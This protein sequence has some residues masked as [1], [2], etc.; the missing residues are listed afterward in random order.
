MPLSS[1][2]GKIA[3]L[4][5][6]GYEGDLRVTAIERHFGVFRLVHFVLD[7]ET[8]QPV[9]ETMQVRVLDDWLTAQTDSPNLE[10]IARLH[11]RELALIVDNYYHGARQGDGGLYFLVD[12]FPR[13]AP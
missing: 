2:T 3:G 13:D 12:P 8:W 5:C 7:L 9:L 10:G 4:T 6:Q 1:S 11:E